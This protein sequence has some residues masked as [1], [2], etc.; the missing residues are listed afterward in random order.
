M[1]LP[2]NLGFVRFGRLAVRLGERRLSVLED[3]IDA[4][5]HLGRHRELVGEL[6]TLVRA[7]PLRERFWGQLMIA[8]YRSGRQADALRAYQRARTTLVDELGIE[9]GPALRGLDEAILQQPVELDLPEARPPTGDLGR[10]SAPLRAAA[11]FVGRDRELL[12]LSGAWARVRRSGR[13]VV[14]VSGEPGIGKTR[15]A[16]H[17]AARAGADGAVVVSGRCEEEMLVPYQPFGEALAR[18]ADG[19]SRDVLGPHLRGPAG[20]LAGLVPGPGAEDRGGVSRPDPETERLHLFEA[21]TALLSTAASAAPVLL[22]LDDL[23]WATKPTLL[24]LRHVVRH[25]STLPLLIIVTYRDTEAA[26]TP[27]L[28]AALADLW[29]NQGVSRVRLSGLS[30]DDVVALVT[31]STPTGTSG[32]DALGT[33][34]WTQTSGNPFFVTEMVR[35]LA[36]DDDAVAGGP[37]EVPDSVRDVIAHRVS[38]LPDDARAALDVASVIGLHFRLDVL[39]RAGDLLDVVAVDAVESA[40]AAGLVEEVPDAIDR[41]R[42]AHALVRQTLLRRLGASRRA[43][44]HHR[45]ATVLEATDGPASFDLALIAHHYAEGG[46]S[47][48]VRKAVHFLRLAGDDAIRQLAYEDAVGHFR[49]AVDVLATSP[50]SSPLE[51]CRLLLALGDAVGRAGDPLREQEAFL[52]AARTAQA[53]GHAAE[54]VS[55]AQGLARAVAWGGQAQGQAFEFVEAALAVL[56]QE[57]SSARAQLLGRLARCM[58]LSGSAEERSALAGEAVR[59]ARRLGDPS[60]LGPVLNDWHWAAMGPDHLEERLAVAD[61]MAML[62]LQLDSRDLRASAHRWRLCDLFEAGDVEAARGEAAGMAAVSH[63][64]VSSFDVMQATWEGRFADADRLA[65]DMSRQ[66][67]NY[68]EFG[69]NDGSILVMRWLQGRFLELAPV[70]EP[71]AEVAPFAYLGS[72]AMLRVEQGRRSDAR[73]LVDTLLRREFGGV[74]RNI[75]WYPQITALASVVAEL[76]HTEGAATLYRLLTPYADRNC[77]AGLYAFTGNGSHWLG[78]LAA[79]TGD[80]DGSLA[81]LE[82]ALSRYAEMDAH[83]WWALAAVSCA[84]VLRRTGRGQDAARATGLLAA[85]RS[86]AGRLGMRDIER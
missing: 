50:A 59:M 1:H 49:R 73:D 75:F 76:G 80:V 70:V 60:V 52:E 86:T 23:H 69:T 15:L 24:M 74:A 12:H 4:E 47:G 34:L 26:E 31:A 21:V 79:A 35:Q 14:L 55:A 45:I 58:F 82:A 38:R 18:Y 29:R 77:V 71:A 20:S 9:P 53:G 66:V 28:A 48:D 33:V 54:L 44:L 8:L 63:R 46:P 41:Y 61:E 72:L 11:P 62:S 51:R 40:M 36:N 83:P 37:A 13:E 67:L 2:G 39:A 65:A 3:C 22:I 81:H 17:L 42:F 56:G 6:E 5:L 30:E 7:H 19:A 85:A 57:D 78:V 16:M 25:T 10:R 43:R 84:H 32:A 27:D 68:G 64:P